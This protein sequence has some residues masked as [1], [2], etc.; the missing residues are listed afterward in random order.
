MAATAIGL[1]YP[2]GQYGTASSQTLL[3]DH[4]RKDPFAAALGQSVNRHVMLSSFYPTS[5]YKDCVR[6]S[7]PYMPP[8][9]AAFYDNEYSLARLPSSTFGSIVMKFCRS[10]GNN[11]IAQQLFPVLLFS[12]GLGN[13]RLIYNARGQSLASEGFIVI[14][15]DHP[16]HADIV[17]FPDGATFLAAN[18][19]T[20]EQIE[21]ALDVRVQDVSF[22]IDRLRSK[23]VANSLRCGHSCQNLIGNRRLVMFGHSLGGATA[24]AAALVD[25]RLAASINVDGTQFGPIVTRGAKTPLLMVA[26]DGKTLISDVSWAL[27]WNATQHDTKVAIAVSNTTHGS[28]T[29]FPLIVDSIDGLPQ[30]LRDQ[31]VELIGGMPGSE[32]QH[33][34]STLVGHFVSYA[35]CQNKSPLA[36][37]SGNVSENLHLLGRSV[38]KSWCR[39]HRA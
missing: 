27:T 39:K 7:S 33:L 6:Y 25:N 28:F 38:D 22:I 36:T 16:Y 8:I 15:I 29:D 9:T 13:S 34:V 5:L 17:E 2:A 19:T 35:H 14:M 11:K 10:S 3:V 12:P 30:S 18:I 37:F 1:P 32:V 4:G 26:H 23:S 21:A 24:A 20:D 31:L